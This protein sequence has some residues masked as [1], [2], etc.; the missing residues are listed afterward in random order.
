MTKRR[1]ILL[2][3]LVVAMVLGCVFVGEAIRV[4]VFGRTV[5]HA[6]FAEVQRALVHKATLPEGGSAYSVYSN[7]HIT[8]ANVSIAES[9]VQKWLQAHGASPHELR[10]GSGVPMICDDD[11]GFVEDGWG[12]QF[13]D[14]TIRVTVVYDRDRKI[15]S[16]TCE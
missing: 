5:C 1:K 11:P 9:A 14:G 6:T 4:G 10:Y 13:Q 2:A 8:M 16:I 15:A 7:A 3:V 12:A